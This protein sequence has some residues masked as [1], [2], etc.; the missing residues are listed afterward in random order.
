MQVID[1][2]D[3]TGQ[4][5]GQW[6]KVWNAALETVCYRNAAGR[7]VATAEEAEIFSAVEAAPDP[8]PR[9]RK[10]WS[11]MRSR[12]LYKHRTR[13]GLVAGS[14]EDVLRLE[15]QWDPPIPGWEKESDPDYGVMYVLTPAPRQCR[16]SSS[17]NIR[18]AAPR[19]IL[20]L[21]C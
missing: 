16:A 3:V 2:P 20:V 7:E 13:D 17:T 8:P 10:K 11:K 1:A 15:D 4:A 14:I 9:W 12:V 5:D 19:C 18:P 6:E 21:L